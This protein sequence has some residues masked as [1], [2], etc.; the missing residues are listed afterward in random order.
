[1]R[2]RLPR[3]DR[4]KEW[5]TEGE[6]D[7]TRVVRRLIGLFQSMAADFQP[8]RYGL[9]IFVPRD[10]GGRRRRGGSSVR[11][12]VAGFA[13]GRCVGLLPFCFGHYE[14]LF[15]YYSVK[16]TTFVPIIIR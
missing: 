12:S 10:P 6:A 16:Y 4:N 11:C 9:A 2:G 1:M 13:N 7:V 5:R 8:F 14:T 3:Y 15:L